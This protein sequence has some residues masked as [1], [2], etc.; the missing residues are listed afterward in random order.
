MLDFSDGFDFL[1][2]CDFS[3]GF[4]VPVRICWVISLMDFMR[5]FGFVGCFVLCI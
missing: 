4:Y 5:I 2:A 1:A 3:D